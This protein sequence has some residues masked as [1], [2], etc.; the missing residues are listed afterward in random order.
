MT[1]A[2]CLLISLIAAGGVVGAGASF[3]SG[4]DNGMDDGPVIPGPSTPAPANGSNGSGEP[5]PSE[6]G[7]MGTPTPD[8]RVFDAGTLDGAILMPV[9]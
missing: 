7:G 4:C 1:R 5:P 3:I 9:R 2:R 6:D 8:G